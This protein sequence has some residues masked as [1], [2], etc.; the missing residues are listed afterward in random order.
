MKNARSWIKSIKLIK[1]VTSS[2]GHLILN[3]PY[4]YYVSG[5]TC[6]THLKLYREKLQDIMQNIVEKNWL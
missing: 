6:V 2:D 4:K 1:S 5:N 3:K